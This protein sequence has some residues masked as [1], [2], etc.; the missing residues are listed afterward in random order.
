VPDAAIGPRPAPGHPARA[1]LLR[2]AGYFAFWLVLMGRDA[3]QVGA[4]LMAAVVATWASLRLQ[5]PGP[6]RLRLTAVPRLVLRFA[7]GSVV[8]GW[9]V[10]RRALDPRLPL[11]PGFV[12]Y[13]VRLPPGTVRCAFAAFTSLLPGT[14]PAGDEGSALLYHCLDVGQPVVAQLTAEEAMLSRALRND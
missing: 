11:R 9:D 12:V 4:G 2:A 7:W 1:T 6:G 13:P 3:G 8:A 5:P 10:A 14:V